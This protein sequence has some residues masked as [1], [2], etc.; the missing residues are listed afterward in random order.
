MFVS[1]SKFPFVLYHSEYSFFL[2]Q[3]CSPYPEIRLRQHQHAV[4]RFGVEYFLFYCI[5]FGPLNASWSRFLEVNF[6]QTLNLAFSISKLWVHSLK[7]STLAFMGVLCSFSYF[8]FVS[9]TN[10]HS[11][12]YASSTSL[13]GFLL[14]LYPFFRESDYTTEILIRISG[15]ILAF[16]SFLLVLLSISGLVSHFTSSGLSLLRWI[17]FCSA[18]NCTM[19]TWI[20]WF[21]KTRVVFEYCIVV[22][23]CDSGM[24]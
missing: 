10:P 24:V 18:Q 3:P 5:S 15:V 11:L 17:L 2:D 4:G 19:S 8:I 7:V 1:K 21:Q 16:H 9:K 22:V 20:W 6:Y 12:E 23:F 14:E 13:W